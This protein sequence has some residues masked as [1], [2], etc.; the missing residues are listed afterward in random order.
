MT[1]FMLTFNAGH[2]LM[3]TMATGNEVMLTPLIFCNKWMKVE[4][5]EFK[6]DYGVS[7]FRSNQT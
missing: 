1:N 3:G 5:V 2:E 4:P 6:I 7:L